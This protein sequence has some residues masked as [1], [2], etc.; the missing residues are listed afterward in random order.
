M[1]TAFQYALVIP[2]LLTSADCIS[3]GLNSY[4]NM[5]LLVL[6]LANIFVYKS[7]QFE[8]SFEKEVTNVLV[9]VP[10]S[11]TYQLLGLSMIILFPVLN[12]TMYPI[13][14]LIYLFINLGVITFQWW[15]YLTLFTYF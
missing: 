13:S 9:R 12:N 11:M 1:V 8:C 7:M 5:V 4:I 6:S 3:L 15:E 2:S 14:F 10:K